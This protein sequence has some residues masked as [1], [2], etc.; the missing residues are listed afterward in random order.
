MESALKK[1]LIRN[2]ILI[3]LAVII[4]GCTLLRPDTARAWKTKTHGYSANLLL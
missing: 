2:G 4:A 1:G 3:L